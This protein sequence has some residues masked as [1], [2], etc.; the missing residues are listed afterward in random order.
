MRRKNSTNRAEI[1]KRLEAT[2][3]TGP[4]LGYENVQTITFELREDAHKFWVG[5]LQPVACA[6]DHFGAPLDPWT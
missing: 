5:L 6:L 2:L 1:S 3:G 4:L